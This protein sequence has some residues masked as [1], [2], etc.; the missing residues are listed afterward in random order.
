ME[1]RWKS[2]LNA[3]KSGSTY[4]F[5][6]ALRKHGEDAF[7]YVILESCVNADELVD[8]ERRLICLFGTKN[9]ALGYNMTDGG[10]GASG[11]VISEETRERHRQAQR[12]KKH[13]EETKAKMRESHRNRP[14]ITDETRQKLREH[15][16]RKNP[17]FGHKGNPCDEETRKKISE[18]QKLRLA[19]RRLNRKQEQSTV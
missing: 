13:S 10:E 5:H 17:W 8:T 12:G 19:K 7:E 3:A 11:R 4:R 1:D 18:S 14:P 9:Y 15:A 6:Q 16:K 2:H